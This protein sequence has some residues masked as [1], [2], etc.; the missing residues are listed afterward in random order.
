M[1]DEQINSNEKP[2]FDVLDD[3]EELILD[4]VAALNSVLAELGTSEDGGGSVNIY[5]DKVSGGRTEREY[6]TRY[7]VAGFVN[8]GLLEEIQKDFGGGKY[9]IHVYKPHGQGFATRKVISIAGPVIEKETKKPEESL[10]PVLAVMSEG[11]NKMF[12]AISQ[13]AASQKTP[14]QQQQPSRL[15]MIQEMQAMAE[16]LKPTNQ[17]QQTVDPLEAMKLG[18]EI[19]KSAGGGD[20][21][22]PVWL[23]KMIDVIGAPMV[24]MIE[25]NAQRQRTP[26]AF[27]PPAAAVAG[28]QAQV[29][30]PQ[31]ATI[32]EADEMNIML[33]SYIKLLN[34][35]AERNEPVE[36]HADQ[37]L[38]M[39]PASELD[40]IEQLLAAENWR[41]ELAKKTDV[42]E[43][44]PEWF[45]NL[46]DTILQYIAEDKLTESEKPDIPASHEND[47]GARQ[48][49]GNDSLHGKTT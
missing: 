26:A 25:E 48:P 2:K 45:S 32:N 47:N 20:D 44:H 9:H 38:N 39:I 14:Q 10:A 36:E 23:S 16:V 8:G 37:I 40:N 33:T 1:P 24:K 17:P 22:N 46:R 18:I 11:F 34:K 41:Q 5:R 27:I 28:E 3:T 7:D 19:A 42:I 30:Q 21:S 29:A 15:E 43:K 31:A 35:A 13:I 6:I 4:D 49:V 12:E